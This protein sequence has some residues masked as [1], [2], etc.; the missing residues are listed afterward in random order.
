MPTN[1]RHADWNVRR[2]VTR[3][4]SN[5]RLSPNFFFFR[6]VGRL[7]WDY[8]WHSLAIIIVTIVQEIVAL[9][10]VSLL[11]QLVD[12]LQTGDLGNTIWLLMGASLLY[13]GIVR[14]N[15]ILR[16][17]MFYETDRAKRIELTLG[18]ADRGA[19]SDVEEAGTAHTRVINAVSGITNA[20]YHILGSFTPVIIKSIV[21]GGKLLAYDRLLGIA[22]LASLIV[23]SVMTALFNGKL[24]VL[25]D[26]QYSIISQASGS[27]VKTIADMNNQKA[28]TKF[29]RVVA[30]RK[31][32]LI[33]LVS[34]SQTFIYIREVAL[35]GSQFLVVLLALG[36]RQR[37]GLTP[38]DF[39]KIIGYTTQVAAAFITTATVLDAIVSYSRAYHVF[40]KARETVSA[41]TSAL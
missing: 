35:I 20:A 25:R 34:K 9:W 8:R 17:K 26:S 36:M 28:R 33:S 2:A 13:P 38:G 31:N 3:L 16:H 11:G 7:I 1:S 41:P 24:R 37:L 40:A 18:E 32:T 10:P 14:G 23:P 22:Y 15:I 39:T 30:E 21:V 12:Q 4:L 19:C 27:G 5:A 29:L 6:D